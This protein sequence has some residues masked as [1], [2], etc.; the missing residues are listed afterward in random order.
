MKPTPNQLSLYHVFLASPGDVEAERQYVRR[1]F[2]EYN[3]HTAHIWRAR[4]EVVDW[5]NYATIGLGRP[6]ELITRQTLEK[7]R[8]SLALVIG[9]MG[10]RFGSPSGKAESGT[11]EEFNWAMESHKASGFPEFKWFFRKVDKL[12]LPADPAEAI[13]A[14][15]QWQKVL[16][17]R[18]RM[19]DLNNP[20]FYAEYQS[21]AGFAEVFARDLNQWLADPARPWAIER[22]P[23]VVQESSLRATEP[24]R[25]AS[26]R[27]AYVSYAWKEERSTDP[28]KAGKVSEFCTRL[29]HCGLSVVRDDQSLQPGDRLSDFMRRLGDS[30]RIFIFLSDAYLK[31]PNCMF[32]FLRIWQSSS[33]DQEKFRRRTRVYTMPGADISSITNRLRYAKYWRE[34]WSDLR[35][36]IRDNFE[37]LG[38]SD[39]KA[40]QRIQQFALQVNEM[41]AQV[42]DVLQAGDLEHFI[43]GAISELSADR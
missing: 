30:D 41:L 39:L 12:E 35:E 31:S 40:W 13:N 34:Q 37:M 25:P 18:K 28:A 20:V 5:E 19:Q 26:L 3:R 23:R 10:Q 11:E 27:E 43:A 9:I 8:E 29:V 17:F 42:Q 33:D 6:Q 1:F 4:F 14:L 21:S 24:R 2:D 36:E 22:T 38:P 32:E 16:A 7:Y 15:E